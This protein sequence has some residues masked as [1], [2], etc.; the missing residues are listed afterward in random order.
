MLLSTL[1]ILLPSFLM[2]C[3]DIFYFSEVLSL[4]H[5]N[6]KCKRF[7]DHVNFNIAFK[8]DSIYNFF[9][10][11]YY[12]S[13]KVA[14]SSKANVTLQGL[15]NMEYG[16]NDNVIQTNVTII[17]TNNNATIFI[18]DSED[19]KLANLTLV[20]CS[21]SIND[22]RII[23]LKYMSIQDSPW[24]ALYLF[25]VCN[26][27]II[28]S[29][30]TRNGKK[31][32]K[33][34][35][36][37]LI[38]NKPFLCNCNCCIM[39][40]NVTDI[41]SA[42]VYISLFDAMKLY[43]TSLFLSNDVDAYGI[44]AH[45]YTNQYELKIDNFLSTGGYSAFYI[46]QT[47]PQVYEN[48][49][50]PFINITNAV[51]RDCIG[52][53]IV[54]F[55]NTSTT[56]SVYI[57][58]SLFYNNTGNGASALYI[59][60]LYHV[61]KFN[62]HLSNLT[63]NDNS[64]DHT[65]TLF[66]K[67]D[68]T[69]YFDVTVALIFIK[70]ISITNCT[71]SN[72]NGTGLFLY[73]S[74]PTFYGN[75]RFINN[76]GE[77]GGGIF[78]ISVSILLLNESAY[79][80]FINNHAKNKGGAICITQL[81]FRYLK[82]QNVFFGYCF[83][84]G[85]HSLIEKEYFHFENNSAG[86]AGYSVYGSM[87]SLCNS[88][89]AQISTGAVGNNYSDYSIISSD[90]RDICFCNENVP[91][92][93][94]T[95]INVDAFPGETITIPVV[96]V[97]DENG[98]TIGVVTIIDKRS[99]IPDYSEHLSSQCTN[100]S[101]KIRAADS[102]EASINIIVTLSHHETNFIPTTKNVSV[103]IQSCP[104]GFHVSN[105]TGVCE[106]LNE[107][108]KVATCNTTD[109]TVTRN[110]TTWLGYDSDKNCT[111][112]S[113]KCRST[114]C[115][116]SSVTLQLSQRDTQ[117]ESNR[118]GRLCGKCSEK[119]SLVLGSDK[120]KLCD[121]NAYLTLIILFA[122]AG[123]VLVTFLIALNLTVS[124]GT[125][126]GLIFFANIV[127]LY[128]PLFPFRSTFSVVKQFIDWTNLDLGFQT[129]FYVGMDSCQK[130]GLQ[131]VFTFYVWFLIALIIL[132]SRQSSKLTKVVGNNAV[133]VLA[134][135]LLLSYTKLLRTIILI[136]SPSEI[137]CIDKNDI[138]TN[139]WFVDATIPYAT[140]CHLPLF[141]FAMFFLIVFI[142]PYTLFL[143]LFPFFEVHQPKWKIT[144]LL[145]LNLKPV[146]D[147]Y[148]GPHNDKFRCWPGVLAASRVVLAL[149]VTL[150][151]KGTSIPFS[152]L[153]AITTILI[154]TLSFGKIYKSQ[155]YHILDIWYLLSLLI[156]VYIIEGTLSRDDYMSS[157]DA[158]IGVAIVIGVGLLLFL[159]ILFYHIL[160][161]FAFLKWLKKK[162]KARKTENTQIQTTIELA[163]FTE[164]AKSMSS[165]ISSTTININDYS[166]DIREPLLETLPE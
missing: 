45:L 103:K 110:K 143:L 115:Y 134:T 39:N 121:S 162:F 146:M 11:T 15:G 61:T 47:H 29:S 165:K 40:V 76:T 147:A 8:N 91:I 17:C 81:Y 68:I 120:C 75:I 19:I 79:L 82:D 78:M 104:R 153:V 59:I 109:Q 64:H 52:N 117:C 140:N 145:F 71:F 62:V 6:T 152:I 105:I 25:Q 27:T 46:K 60:Q 33:T 85:L 35:S 133:P 73:E 66:L 139:Y 125:I 119:L 21:L 131:F 102:T 69:P 106:C 58:S 72:N 158:A 20:N 28:D 54:I 166:V 97:G 116:V 94:E 88:P 80:V 77:N 32:T 24:I 149:S 113:K 101:Y 161:Y 38:V 150:S 137:T 48:H 63:F 44:I 124:V 70:N 31:A 1:F 53:G 114:Y 22:S 67:N 159:V 92:C 123:V 2:V 129:C 164:E 5:Q 12:L 107:I 56:G 13:N 7:S 148:G 83:Y 90:A 43:F 41:K 98:A 128:Q 14:I 99:L 122:L 65:E 111:V 144:T 155:Y 34:C 156:I 57:A 23:K 4:C 55:W 160:Y 138:S 84:Y 151:Y 157:L 9:E 49:N 130:M 87:L 86:V 3:G 135:L 89:L 163:K 136:L 18:L 96:A 42:G 74:I 127:K 118:T 132:M 142:I 16:A 154:I 108:S 37:A 51:I 50:T 36:I 93:Y 95:S 30:F 100:I 10:G 112:V 26:I 141:V 126:N